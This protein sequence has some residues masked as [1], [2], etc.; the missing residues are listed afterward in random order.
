VAEVVR[1]SDEGGLV[2]MN[3]YL[4]LRTL[5]TGVLYSPSLNYVNCQY[6]E[7]AGFQSS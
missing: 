3:A 7:L 6:P 5:L 2:D 1:Q 4:T